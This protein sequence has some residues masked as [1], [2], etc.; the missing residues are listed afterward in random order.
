MPVCPERVFR[1][2]RFAVVEVA[3]MVTTE[4]ESGVVVP[5][6]RLSVWVVRWTRVPESVKPERFW[7]EVPQMMFP[8]ESVVRELEPEQDWTVAI[9]KPPAEMLSPCRVFVALAFVCRILPPEMVRP[10]VE[11]SPPAPVENI[12]PENVDV[13][14][15]PRIVVVAVPPTPI[16]LIAASPKE[17]VEVAVVEVAENVRKFGFTLSTSLNSWLSE[18]EVIISEVFCPA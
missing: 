14:L 9:F 17:I 10:L 16:E 1:V 11:A 5:I 13:E 7:V 2:R 8:E 3:A 4:R 12:P 6:E 18:M 15:L